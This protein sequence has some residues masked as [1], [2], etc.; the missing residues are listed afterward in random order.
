M[1]DCLVAL[2]HRTVSGRALFA[3][4]SDRP[5]SES[6]VIRWNPPRRDTAPISATHITIDPWEAT[7]HACVLSMPDWCWGAEH[8][9][10]EHGVAI[11]NETIYT[12]LDPRTAPVALIGMD[13]VRLGL[14]RASTAREAAGV[15]AGLIERYGQGGS[16]HDPRGGARPRPYWSSFLIADPTDAWVVETSGNLVSSM[17]VDSTWA[18]SN[19]T[20]IPD[21]DR[22][23]RHPRQPVER[24]VN[25]R[26]EAS[27]RVLSGERLSPEDL[28]AHLSSHVGGDDGWTVCMH[29]R[30][31]DDLVEMTTASMVAELDPADPVIRW[32]QGSPCET[33]YRSAR[34]SEMAGI[35]PSL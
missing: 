15:I 9:V 20:T 24:L 6:Q 25:P 18:I 29:A 32:T 21:F 30:Q 17:K 14:E 12:T 27:L 28:C 16:G 10:N 19:R 23:H 7:T 26:L 22:A 3:K 4:N 2:G 31:G 8:G 11:G 34:F 13:L 33:G 1:C 5:P 35:V